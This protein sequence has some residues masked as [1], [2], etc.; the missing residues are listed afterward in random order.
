MRGKPKHAVLIILWITLT[1]LI[2]YLGDVS[3]LGKTYLT[4][5]FLSGQ[6]YNE[7]CLLLLTLPVIYAAFIFRIKGGIIASL[8]AS[9]AITPHAF[10]FSPNLDPFF[11]LITFAILTL[12]LAA[13]IGNRLNSQ[14][15]LQ[16]EH[17]RLE[18]FLSETLGAQE[19]ER[20]YLAR[21]LHDETL[22]ALVDV[23]HNIDDLI[24]K[25]Y[26]DATENSL[27]QLHGE[28][29]N[30]LEGTRY[31]IRGLR[32]PLLDEMGLGASLKWLVEEAAW[33]EHVKVI[34]NI[35]EEDLRMPDNVELALYRIAQEALNNARKYSRASKI[36]LS[37][38][39]TGEKVK[40]R[41][42]D[43]GVGFS[44]AP[45]DKLLSE[46]K[47]GLVGMMERARL[48]TGDARIE[49]HVGKGTVVTVEV[50][51]TRDREISSA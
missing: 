18:H 12:L 5:H 34:V 40:L 11:R 29:D 41:I 20:R 4:W 42:A 51:V 17:A 32:P 14:E 22:Q 30:I 46:G 9:A 37:L 31:F 50:P 38:D 35:P 24:E 39:F 26:D 27:K 25:A 45:Q 10:L 8:L 2:Y 44:I 7:F 36:E 47:F 13:L 43:D 28:I 48:I 16:K 21:E 6:A 33:D 15:R 49:S 23:S 3:W 1:S 19:K